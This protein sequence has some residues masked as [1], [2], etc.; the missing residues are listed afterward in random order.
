ML[1]QTEFQGA[2]FVAVPNHVVNG[3]LGADALGVLVWLAARPV[4]S[5]VSVVSIRK[6]FGFGKDKWQRISRE[7][8]DAGALISTAVQCPETGR[9]VGK[10]FLVRWPEKRAG[11][12]EPENPAHGAEPKAGKPGSRAGKPGHEK[13]ENPAPIKRNIQKEGG[14]DEV[15]L[16]GLW[17][18]TK[19]QRSLLREGKPLVLATGRSLRPDRPEYRA[20]RKALAVG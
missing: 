7:L 11:T 14:G 1:I 17:D 16:P 12:H 18:L 9:I 13:P 4:G 10:S 2:G 5:V 8:R 15:E 19:F 20:L 6:R 3:T